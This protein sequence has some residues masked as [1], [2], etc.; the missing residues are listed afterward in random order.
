MKGV[1]G[2]EDGDWLVEASVLEMEVVF[3]IFFVL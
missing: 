3:I 1:R 2:G